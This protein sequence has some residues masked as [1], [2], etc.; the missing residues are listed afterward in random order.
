MN[1]LVTTKKQNYTLTSHDIEDIKKMSSSLLQTG[2][3]QKLGASGIFAVVQMARSLGI[4]EVMALNGGL[5][6]VDGKIEMEGKLMMALI[7]QAGHSVTKDKTSNKLSCTLHGKRHDTGDTWSE[8]FGIEDAKAAGLL[9]RGSYQKYGATM[10]QWRALSRLANFLFSDVTKGCYVMGEISDSPK[11]NDPVNIEAE[12]EI[13]KKIELEQKKNIEIII[14]P[15]SLIK[16][17]SSCKMISQ[18]EISWIETSLKDFPTLKEKVDKTL[19]K[20]FISSYQDI[21]K[22]LYETMKTYIQGELK[23][24]LS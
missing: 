21:P 2:H 19:K 3:Y 24:A 6:P 12:E 16:K 11:L 8:T 10:F 7:R 15:S 18:E 22:Q 23:N 5:Y 4:D 13:A 20:K 17:N 9:S 14:E 1:S